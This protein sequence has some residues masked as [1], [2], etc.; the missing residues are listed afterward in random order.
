MREM[1]YGLR[2]AVSSPNRNARTAVVIGRLLGAAFTICLFT[3]L[4]SH[5][6]QDPASWMRFPTSPVSL[7][8]FTQGIH[9]TSGIACFPLLFAKLYAVMPQ[10]FK[11]PPIKSVVEG[12]ERGSIAIFV[13][14]S[15]VEIFTGLL[16]TFQYYP[17]PFDFRQTHFAMA[18]VIGGSLAVHIGV[19]L[20]LIQRY[21]LKKN[22]YDANGDFITPEE[23]VVPPSAQ[24]TARAR[25]AA[26]DLDEAG[27]RDPALVYSKGLTDDVVASRP[28]RGVV[29]R[30][31]D[32]ID[33]TPQVDKMSS[34]RGFFASIG[35]TTAAVVAFTVG[36]SATP[37]TGI[38]FFA[39]RK[40]GYGPN[41]LPINRSAAAAQVLET[42]M[43]PDWTLTVTRGDASN[44]FTLEQLE[45]MPQYEAALPIACVEGW[46]QMAHWKGVRLHD[47]VSLVGA[48]EP[49]S[50]KV[51]SLEKKGGYRIMLMGS[52]YVHDPSTLVALHLNGERLDIEHG[53]PARMIAPGRPGVLQTKWLS[54]I[55]VLT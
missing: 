9:I 11:F 16:D 44:S 25:L 10:L 13:A 40:N 3:G 28:P 24:Q 5:F 26:Q 47:L 54:T 29:G 45:A 1:L 34:R 38:N 43:S 15:L 22:S 12:L 8:R 6:L 49:E 50:L 51:T 19:K 52:E 20:P 27:L 21:W 18:I 31:F 46:S 36:Q 48:T 37:F 2:R 35:V 7:Y 30:V 32:W 53:Y 14:A 4:Y 33:R 23:D 39:P 41:S 42:A 17:E 55:E